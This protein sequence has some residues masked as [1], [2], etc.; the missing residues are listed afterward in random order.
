MLF[1]GLGGI[2]QRHLRNLRSLLG[3]EVEVLAYRV[4]RQSQVVTDQLGIEEGASVEQKYDVR[5]F[6]DLDEALRQRPAAA[7]ICNPTSA[8]LSVALKAARAGCHLFLEKPLSH[9]PE[10]V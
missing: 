3:S 9:S 7:F 5:V 10:G 1:V 4:R 8:H 2:G 6:D